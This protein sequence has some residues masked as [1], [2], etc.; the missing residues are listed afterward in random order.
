[1]SSEIYEKIR[2]NPKFTQLVNT[3]SRYAWMLA[4][5]VLVVFY[6]FI[7]VV[8]FNPSL[9]GVRLGEGSMVTSGAVIIFLMFLFFWG[10]TALYVNRANTEFDAL[11]QGLLQ[12]A[13]RGA[14][15]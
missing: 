12:D 9:M 7:L 5:T 4:L 15:K 10:L 14:K 1:M 11:T 13:T 8:A 2:S 3:R 6:G